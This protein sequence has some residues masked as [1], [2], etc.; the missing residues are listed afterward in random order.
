M[1]QIRYRLWGISGNLGAR[2]STT[3]GSILSARDKK[4]SVS[5]N[6]PLV[7][8]EIEANPQSKSFGNSVVTGRADRSEGFHDSRREKRRLSL[9]T[10]RNIWCNEVRRHPQRGHEAS[11]R[12]RFSHR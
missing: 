9:R 4:H 8:F 2:Y 10:A 11:L 6:F 12:P 1:A 3:I 7:A 5:W